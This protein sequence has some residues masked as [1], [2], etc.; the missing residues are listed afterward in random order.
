MKALFIALIV[1][2]DAGMAIQSA[3]N[4]QLGIRV[5]HAPLY[6]ATWSFF[7]GFLALVFVSMFSGQLDKSILQNALS[8]LG[9]IKLVD[10]WALL[11]SQWSF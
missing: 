8:Q 6:V 11:S 7:I 1:L 3:I 5:G 2:L 10:L 9:I 4:S